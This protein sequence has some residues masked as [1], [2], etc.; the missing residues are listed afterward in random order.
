M[1]TYTVFS[2]ATGSIA[3]SYGADAAIEWSDF[4]FTLFDHIAQPPATAPVIHRYA[5]RTELTHEEF[6]ELFT[7]E[8]QWS[9]D[10]FEAGFEVMVLNAETKNRIRSGLKSY[11]AA[12]FVDLANNKVQLVLGVFAGL[13]LIAPARILEILNG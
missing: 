3:Y 8:E 7:A 2:K 6:R 10:A 11:Y 5:G 4:P 1:T 9:I 13:G 12:T